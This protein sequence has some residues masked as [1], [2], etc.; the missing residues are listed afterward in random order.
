MEL[1][2]ISKLYHTLRQQTKCTAM[3]G[4]FQPF[5]MVIYKVTYDLNALFFQQVMKFL[6]MIRKES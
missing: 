3:N 5:K 1:L 4:Y 2:K 6:E